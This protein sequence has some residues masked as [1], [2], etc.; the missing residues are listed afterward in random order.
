[1]FI[2]ISPVPKPR[3]TRRDKWAGRKSVVNYWEYK[4]KIKAA[5][6]GTE[7]EG[8]IWLMFG[9]KMPEYWS[10]RKKAAH[11]G[12]PHQSKPDIDNLVKGF[13]DALLDDDA[14]IWEVHARKVWVDVPFIRYG[15]EEFIDIFENKTIEKE[16]QS[17]T[18][19]EEKISYRPTRGTGSA[20]SDGVRGMLPRTQ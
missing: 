4:D 12:Q 6:K 14:R 15:K 9:I 1:M 11:M 20:G 19:P 7:V 10:V 3:M 16:R 18:V 2:E 13:L 5:M 17:T 8:R